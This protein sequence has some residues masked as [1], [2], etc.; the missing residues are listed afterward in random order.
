MSN[1]SPQYLWLGHH[2]ENVSAE[3]VQ[4]LQRRYSGLQGEHQIHWLVSSE[5]YSQAHLTQTQRDPEERSQEGGGWR[6]R[7]MSLQTKAIKGFWSQEKLE[8]GK[9]LIPS[10]SFQKDSTRPQRD[11]THLAS[12]L[13]WN[14]C[15]F[16]WATS[17]WP[18][19][20]AAVGHWPSHTPCQCPLWALISFKAVK[21]PPTSLTDISEHFRWLTS[22]W[23][24]ARK[25][26]LVGTWDHCQKGP[27]SRWQGDVSPLW[28]G[29]LAG[30]SAKGFL[31]QGFEWA[32]ETQGNVMRRCL[33]GICLSNKA[34]RE[35]KEVIVSDKEKNGS[36]TKSST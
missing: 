16:L 18:S 8:R 35:I 22:Q 3:A 1:S 15:L 25:P 5:E 20:E 17:V 29:W 23:A 11:F 28:T 30:S 2:T 14:T 33:E 36:F 24:P 6:E 32:L 10:Q 4:A 7:M 31:F 26:R 12:G 27:D 34:S 9:A 19:V 21:A 13:R